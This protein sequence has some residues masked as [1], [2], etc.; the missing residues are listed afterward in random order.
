MGTAAAHEIAQHLAHLAGQ[1]LELRQ[2]E[3]AQVVR[4]LDRGQDAEFVISIIRTAI[5]SAAISN[6]FVASHTNW[7]R[8]RKRL[9]LRSEYLDHSTG[10]VDELCRPAPAFVDAQQVREMSALPRSASLATR[11]PTA[12]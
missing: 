6:D 1:P 5:R 9:G 4:R 2:R 12:A 11:L 7:A 10:L 3:L 8:A